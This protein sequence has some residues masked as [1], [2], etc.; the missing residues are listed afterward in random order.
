VAGSCILLSRKHYCEVGGLNE[1][2]LSEAYYDI[3]LCLKLREK[4][5]RNVWTPYAEMVH[6]EPVSKE[7]KSSQSNMNRESKEL[8]FIQKRWKDIIVD[9]PAYS[10]NL[11]IT[12]QDFNYA[13]PPRVDE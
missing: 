7:H 13:W 3:D 1:Q 12:S 10:R 2:E 6:H 11:S 8:A 5:L 9:D 4:E